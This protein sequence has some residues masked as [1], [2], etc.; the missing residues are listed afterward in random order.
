MKRRIYLVT[1]VELATMVVGSEAWAVC[2]VDQN[3]KGKN[4]G[5]TWANAYVH[6]QLALINGCREIWVARGVYTPVLA[7]SDP[8]VSFDIPDR[9]KMYGGF[10]GNETSIDQRLPPINQTV[11][12]GD[13]D[14]NDHNPGNWTDRTST[15]VVG[16]NSHHI[17]AFNST[18]ESP[19]TSSTSLDGFLIVGGDSYDALEAGSA[20]GCLGESESAECAPVL[21]NLSLIGNRSWAAGAIF[22]HGGGAVEISNSVF[23]GNVATQGGALFVDK[24]F[25]LSLVSNCAFINNNAFAGGA[26]ALYGRVEIDNTTF[27]GNTA[28]GSV[29]GG[30]LEVESNELTLTNATF[31][32]NSA[33]RIGG[34]IVGSRG[35]PVSIRNTIFWKNGADSDHNYDDVAIFGPAI[36]EHSVI[37]AGCPAGFTC[38]SIVLTDPKLS[39]AGDHRGA[40]VTF[41]P[42]SGGGAIDS[43]DDAICLRSDQRGVTRPQGAHCDIGAVEWQPSDDIIFKNGFL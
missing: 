9:T 11:L 20:I 43:G 16:N 19:I 42:G 29:G 15:D 6:P 21:N 2:Y 3:A 27:G 12:S 22:L 41:L 14:H 26:A 1:L 4:D 40:T 36:L 7:G 30:A 5:S 18:S 25:G 31:S 32:D 38:A 24:P 13:V 39:S 8:T 34:A 37:A 28:T 10:T 17:V 33:S 23:I 35:V